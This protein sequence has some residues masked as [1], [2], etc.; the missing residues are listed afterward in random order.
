MSKIDIRGHSKLTDSLIMPLFCTHKNI[1]YIN[2]A[3]CKNITNESIMLLSK[4]NKNITHINLIG[5]CMITD[6]SIFELS[7]T[8]KNIINIALGQCNK[9]TDKSIIELSKTNVGITCIDLSNC[10]ITDKSITILSATNKNITDI[11]LNNCD[12]TDKSILALSV[13]N[14]N[15][16]NISLVGC[17][18]ISCISLWHLF[19]NCLNLNYVDIRKSNIK[20]IPCNISTFQNGKCLIALNNYDFIDENERYIFGDHYNVD[21]IFCTVDRIRPF[22]VNKFKYG[23]VRKLTL[24]NDKY[25]HD[26]Y[27][28]PNF[29]Y[30]FICCEGMVQKQSNIFQYLLNNTSKLFDINLMKLIFTHLHKIKFN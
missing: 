24:I 17:Y 2:L 5:C 23:I 25:Y 14:K 6:A 27:Y 28:E 16:I 10:D 21:T 18:K 11:T 12:I 26:I 13:I 3:S 1:T 9:I 20:T 30:S 8:N 19:N 29:K 4:T 15:I 22:Y 7:K